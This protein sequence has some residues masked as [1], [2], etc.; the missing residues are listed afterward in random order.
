MSTFSKLQS[1]DKLFVGAALL[2][3]FLTTF[4]LAQGWSG[5]GDFLPRAVFLVLV[6]V[7]YSPL[8]FNLD[9]ALIVIYFFYMII[10][11]AH[12]F[13][14]GIMGNIMEQLIPLALANYFFQGKNS[15]QSIWFGRFAIAISAFIMLNT[16]IVDVFTPGIVRSMVMF[17]AE[18]KTELGLQ[19][20]KMGVCVYSFAMISMC[21]APVFLY[22]FKIKRKPVFALLFF[23]TCYFVYIA[24]ISTCLLILLL[25]L[26][27]FVISSQNNMKLSIPIILFV[28]SMGYF[29]GLAIVEFVLPYLEGT[30][31]Y[32]HLAG[33]MEFY[34]KTTT[35][36]ETYDVEGRT[37][38][39]K[40]SLD[41]FIHN[42]LF[43]NASGKNGGHNFFL[44]HFARSGVVGMAPFIIYMVRRFKCALRIL[45][46]PSKTIY[47]ICIIG[48][49]IL[50]LL[51]GMSGIDFWTYMYVYIP[52]MLKLAESLTKH[53]TT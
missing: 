11:G 32:G 30:N 33:L 12:G 43:G 25:M 18:G 8:L 39:Y 7:L 26:V 31:F 3:L 15:I 14:V 9:T 53:K 50:G 4:P 36:T 23:L 45:S 29:L 28:I 6:L 20:T 42:P 38:L 46:N 21:L 16:I 52:C 51:K 48:F 44:D 10:C 17:S 34:G 40:Y 27:L 24:G 37:E 41:T 13:D 2:C 5:L 1:N 22:L 49:I 35:V 47:A 19:Y